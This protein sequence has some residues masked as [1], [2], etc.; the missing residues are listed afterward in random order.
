MML[1]FDMSVFGCGDYSNVGLFQSYLSR[2]LNH[3]AAAKIGGEFSVTT[4]YGSDCSWPALRVTHMARQ[5]T[6]ALWVYHPCGADE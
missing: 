4:F 3:S 5:T 2:Y 1:S 6:E